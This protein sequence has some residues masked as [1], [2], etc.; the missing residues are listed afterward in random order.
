[1]V[2]AGTLSVPAFAI[3]LQP[4]F[5]TGPLAASQVTPSC[6]NW[7]KNLSCADNNQQAVDDVVDQL[8]SGGSGLTVVQTQTPTGVGSFTFS[9]LSTGK[10]LLKLNVKQNTSVGALSVTF[11]GD[12]GSNYAEGLPR[13]IG[14][15]YYY[16][17]SNPTTSFLCL[18]GNLVDVGRSIT[19]LINFQTDASSVNNIS[20]SSSEY[21]Y[22]TAGSGFVSSS[23]MG[24]YSGSAPLSSI[25]FTTS[26]GTVTGTASLYQ[27][28]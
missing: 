6:T 7:S 14:S 4:G 23:S 24:L 1:M 16:S 20:Y 19:L 9:G 2:L 3:N 22:S 25:T 13:G 12:T 28:S 15:T 10:Y 26:G 21:A 11:N 5:D 18:A 8:S 27:Y 17:Q